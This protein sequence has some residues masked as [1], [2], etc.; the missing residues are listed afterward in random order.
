M[1]VSIHLKMPPFTLHQV[2]LKPGDAV[3]IFSDGYA[4]QFGGPQG[5][6]FKYRPFKELL[7]DLSEKKMDAAGAQ[8]DRVFEEWKGENEQVDDVV[9]IGLKF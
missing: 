5:K 6:T 2:R 4:D 3:Y 7:T 1:P 8:L 9:I